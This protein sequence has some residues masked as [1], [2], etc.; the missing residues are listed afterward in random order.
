MLHKN[1]LYAVLAITLA[2]AIASFSLAYTNAEPPSPRLYFSA[3]AI[4]QDGRGVIVP[5]RMYLVHGNGR[6]LVNVAGTTFSDDVEN[7]LR[8]ARQNAERI[9]KTSLKGVDIVLETAEEKQAVSGESAGTVFTMAIA[10]LSTGRPLKQG[11]VVSAAI[12]EDGV[13]EEVDGVEE[14]IL[15]AFAADKKIFV[16]SLKQNIRDQQALENLGVV[17]IRAQ[18]VS[19]AAETLLS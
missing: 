1:Q 7:S 19:Q 10:S 12:D 5:F 4:T 6:I 11:A 16:V 8:K 9:T 13:L 14:K 2:A 18:N 15:A 3:A 17:I